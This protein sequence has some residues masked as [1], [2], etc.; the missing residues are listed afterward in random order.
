MTDTR[1]RVDQLRAGLEARRTRTRQPV[2][3]HPFMRWLRSPILGRNPAHAQDSPFS[4][5]LADGRREGLDEGYRLGYAAGYS[6]GVQ[7]G[8]AGGE[9]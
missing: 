4:Q 1:A 5:G 3:R 9:D 2:R 7:A 6:D 8:S